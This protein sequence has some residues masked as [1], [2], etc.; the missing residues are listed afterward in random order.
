MADPISITTRAAKG[1]AL[2]STEVDANF[3]N[4]KNRVETNED[5]ALLSVV[6]MMMPYM[7]ATAPT[8]WLLL[9]GS[10]VS[11]TTYSVLFNHV[12]DEAIIGVGK[13][14]GVGDGSTTFVLPDM[15]GE[16]ARGKEASDVLGSQVGAQ[17][18]AIDHTHTHGLQLP[19]HTHD[20][21]ETTKVDS[22]DEVGT[23]T[24]VTS[25]PATEQNAPATAI[26]GSINSVDQDIDVT[27]PSRN[28][29]WLIKY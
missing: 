7:G 13:A 11:R 25:V 1:E 3:T 18:V 17:D 9:D 12:T 26:D 20:V 14:F 24:V 22:A 2:T 16:V 15:R 4:L 23:T 5:A 29:N 21:V 28:I 8:G 10:T 27:Q 6:G 19:Q